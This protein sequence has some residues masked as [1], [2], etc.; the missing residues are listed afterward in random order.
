MLTT[1]RAWLKTPLLALLAWPPFRRRAVYE[2]R[3]RYYPELSNVIPLSHNLECPLLFPD[4]W[5]S[6]AETFVQQEYAAV[7]EHLPLPRRWLDLGC[8]AGFFSLYVTWRRALADQSDPGTALLIDADSRMRVSVRELIARNRLDGRFEFVH[9]MIGARE[10]LQPFR[11][12]GFMASSAAAYGAANGVLTEIAVLTDPAITAR[13]E[14]PY[15]LVKV[16]IEGGEY[17]FVSH[18]DGVLTGARAVLLEWH[19]GD[20]AGRDAGFVT[21][22]LGLRGFELQRSFPP[23]CRGDNDNGRQAGLMLFVRP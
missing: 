4:A 13:L 16:D 1:A 20:P 17:D 8:H 11:E 2:L 23:T 6:F 18:Y 12:R 9:G 15:D 21:N 10:G 3:Q 19:A 5:A 7:F 22:E 14:P